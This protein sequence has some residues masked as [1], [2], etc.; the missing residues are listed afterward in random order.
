MKLHLTALLITLCFS[1]VSAQDNWPEHFHYQKLNNGLEVLVVEDHSVPLVTIELAVRN[2]A[3]VETPE[4]NGL[5]H[6]YEHLFFKQNGAYPTNDSIMHR[7]DELGIVF[8]ATTS[9]ER[10]NYYINLSSHLVNEG[11]EFMSAAVRQP[12]FTEANIE[13]EFDVIDAKFQRAENNPVHF[14]VQDMNEKLWGAYASRKNALGDWE[15][16]SNATPEQLTEMHENFYV[17]NNSLLIVS[18]DVNPSSIFE[19]CRRVLG[20]WKARSPSPINDNTI[21]EFSPLATSESVITLNENAQSPLVISAFRGPE[22]RNDSPGTLATEVLAYMLSQQQSALSKE[23]VESGLAYQVG[24]GFST[25]KYGSPLTIF[26]V[27]EPQRIG[28]A[29]K[30]LANNI[31]RWDDPEYFTDEE[32]E[33]ARRMLIIQELYSR[34]N[35]SEIVH[36]IS[37]WWAS[38]DIDYFSN[39]TDNI[40]KVTREDISRVVNTY[41]KGQPNITGL[42]M[43]LETKQ[44]LGISNFSPLNTQSK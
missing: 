6:L 22:T 34:E 31:A 20:N 12:I 39:Y 13:G 14:L 44:M 21:P 28:E 37:Y 17:P 2:G 9:D 3:M 4:T 1:I 43:S 26:M 36:N 18:G 32:I 29:M 7:I 5:A 15:V 16:I 24:V 19:Q 42:L 8:N 38:A 40:E 27:P 35:P 30:T 25:Q 33:N 11:I 10:T 23:L 41:I